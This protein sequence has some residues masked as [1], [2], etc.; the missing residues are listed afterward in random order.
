MKMTAVRCGLGRS[1]GFEEGT[2]RQKPGGRPFPCLAGE[3]R[4]LACGSRP[5]PFLTAMCICLTHSWKPRGAWGVLGQTDGV[6]CFTEDMVVLSRDRR[7]ATSTL[8]RTGLVATGGLSQ[9]KQ[10]ATAGQVA[11]PAD[12]GVEGPTPLGVGV[13]GGPLRRWSPAAIRPRFRAAMW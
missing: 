8:R 2:K 7:P 1:P 5:V 12:A 4:G 6:S 11:N 3:C 10:G 13:L 9:L